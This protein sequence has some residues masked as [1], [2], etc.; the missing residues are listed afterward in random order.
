MTT[1]S[2]AWGS[3]AV[4]DSLHD[5]TMY[6]YRQLDGEGGP[7][8]LVIHRDF[9]GAGQDVAA[10][11]ARQTEQMKQTFG[12]LVMRSSEGITVAGRGAHK[13]QFTWS[14]AKGAVEQ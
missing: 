11:V 13:L 4:D 12:Q 3:Y 9:K 2:N 5:E 7:F 6:V 14:S 10:Y 1:I 8:A